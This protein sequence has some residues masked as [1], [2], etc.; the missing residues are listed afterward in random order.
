MSDPAVTFGANQLFSTL[1]DFVHKNTEIAVKKERVG[2]NDED[3]DEVISKLFNEMTEARADLEARVYASGP[4]I[5]SQ[6]G[7]LLATYMVTELTISTERK[8]PVKMSLDSHN[9][10]ANPHIDDR[11]KATHGIT[12]SKGFGAIDFLGATAGAAATLKSSRIRIYCSHKDEEDQD[13][14]HYVGENH[15]AMIEVEE[16]WCGVPTTA[17]GSGWDNPEAVTTRDSEGFLETRVTAI[18]AVV[19]AA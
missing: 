14:D 12:L 7:A 11:K 10:T 9:H 6:I 5:P 13:G 15:T 19:M 2:T 17:V 3:G 1:T 4:A 8:Q 18:K 16:I